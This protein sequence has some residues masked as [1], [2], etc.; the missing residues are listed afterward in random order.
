MSHI[1]KVRFTHI[2]DLKLIKLLAMLGDHFK[3]EMIKKMKLKEEEVGDLCYSVKPDQIKVFLE[4]ADRSERIAETTIEKEL[5]FID[6]T[7]SLFDVEL[8]NVED[9]VELGIL[10]A[11]DE[12][13]YVVRD[14]AEILGVCDN[15]EFA[16]VIERRSSAD[17]IEVIRMNR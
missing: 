14:G 12:Y 10:Y 5:I 13:A 4:N 9:L 16:K 7:F 2:Y 1:V 6:G 8:L 3:S 17:T 11:G 15:L